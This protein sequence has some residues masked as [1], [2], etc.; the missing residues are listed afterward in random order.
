M[1]DLASAAKKY[2]QALKDQEL[3]IMEEIVESDYIIH[4]DGITLSVSTAHTERYPQLACHK[5]F[6]CI[7]LP[8]FMH[9]WILTSSCSGSY[10]HG[11]GRDSC[12]DNL[13]CTSAG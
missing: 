9:G 1:T 5:T 10:P 2:D 13:P 12:N 4:A 3:D 6:Q 7:C 8:E 11:N